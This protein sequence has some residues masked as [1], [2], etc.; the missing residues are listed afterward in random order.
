MKNIRKMVL[1]FAMGCLIALMHTDRAEAKSTKVVTLE[2]GKEYKYDLNGD[3][4]TEKIECSTISYNEEQLLIRLTINKKVKYSVKKYYGQG[5]NFSI[6]DI[7]SKDKYK[8]IYVKEEEGNF[9]FSGANFYRYNGKELEQ[10]CSTNAVAISRFVWLSREQ[11]SNGTVVY[12][13]SSPYEECFL[14][15]Y[16]IELPYKVK[17]GKLVLV[18]K[19]S[20]SLNKDAISQFQALKK[21]VAY[22]TK[23]GKEKVFTLQ[24]DEDFYLYKISVKNNDIDYAYIKNASGKKGWIKVPTYEEVYN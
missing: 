21:V 11:S 14:G 7:D 16:D 19:A 15:S 17:N 24:K 10:Y 22:S 9:Q 2:E 18:K 20:Y 8:E 4:K 6:I 5:I 23:G 12:V 13:M 3:G 1:M